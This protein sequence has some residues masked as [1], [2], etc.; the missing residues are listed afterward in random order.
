MKRDHEMEGRRGEGDMK[1]IKFV[2]CACTSSKMNVSIMYC[3]HVLIKS[4]KNKKFK[5]DVNTNDPTGYYDN[6]L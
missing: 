6:I 5:E 4:A 1:R 3:K 2:S